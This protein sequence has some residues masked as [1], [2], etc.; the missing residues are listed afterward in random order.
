[1]GFPVSR[2]ESLAVHR[3]LRYPPPWRAGEDTPRMAGFGAM[4]QAS[5]AGWRKDKG[6]WSK[7]VEG[8]VASPP[9]LQP[10]A[11]PE[12]LLGVAQRCTRPPAG[13]E[14]V[15][16]AREPGWLLHLTKSPTWGRLGAWG[17]E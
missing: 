2:G 14:S 8:W 6:L 5:G 11:E 7:T 17:P 3:P 4:S 16:E 9:D 12:G 13:R 15:P 1:M 10:K